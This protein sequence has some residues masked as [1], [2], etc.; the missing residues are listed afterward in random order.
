MFIPKKSLLILCYR[1]RRGS[2]KMLPWRIDEKW[3]TPEL[4][5]RV[6]KFVIENSSR[7]W[8]TSGC[9]FVMNNRHQHG[10]DGNIQNSLFL[11][12]MHELYLI[13]SGEWVSNN[14]SST[15]YTFIC[16]TETSLTAEAL[17]N[18]LCLVKI[19]VFRGDRVLNKG[20]RCHGGALIAAKESEK[21][22]CNQLT[23]AGFL[24]EGVIVEV[25]VRGYKAS[26]RGF[27]FCCV[28]NP[29]Q[30]SPYRWRAQLAYSNP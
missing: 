6:C 14:Q 20:R 15:D 29:P 22:K 30:E 11:I 4:T 26:K 7:E 19:T 2:R 17:S 21:L 5:R 27:D 23:I 18:S 10:W 8:E 25:Q 3:L 13:M 28:F 1:L 16:L 12:L 9:Q 24:T